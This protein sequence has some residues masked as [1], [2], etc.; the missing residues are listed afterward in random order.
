MA[1]PPGRFAVNESLLQG[2]LQLL[3]VMNYFFIILDC[4]FRC[5]LS[6]CLGLEQHKSDGQ[7]KKN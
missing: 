7:N 6:R 5:L 3:D 1:L 2:S 4:G